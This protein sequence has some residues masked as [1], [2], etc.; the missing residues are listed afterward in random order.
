MGDPPS[1]S[2]RPVHDP[3]QIADLPSAVAAGR[4]FRPGGMRAGR[5][6]AGAANPV[7]GVNDAE[8]ISPAVEVDGDEVRQAV[9][10]ALAFRG[11]A[12]ECGS[13]V[14]QGGV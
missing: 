9:A 8:D 3:V 6:A 4:R 1:Q 2:G 7:Q 10:Q 13:G 11:A 5:S 12:Q 14:D